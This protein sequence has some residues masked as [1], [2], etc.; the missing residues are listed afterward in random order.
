M[1][2]KLEEVYETGGWLPGSY[3]RD[4]Y[5]SKCGSK[6]CLIGMS[7]FLELKERGRETT[8]G[9]NHLN[10]SSLVQ[11]GRDVCPT[12]CELI[13][14][15]AEDPSVKDFFQNASE[16]EKAE[17][18]PEEEWQYRPPEYFNDHLT[19]QIL[20]EHGLTF[21][22]I[23]E[24]DELARQEVLA[25]IRRTRARLLE[26]KAETPE[27]QEPTEEEYDGEDQGEKELVEALV[28]A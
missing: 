5:D 16:E 8:T 11:E 9:S 3:L 14:A 1:L 23:E 15:F 4:S 25:M 24:A 27:P 26:F 22:E 17:I 20:R 21:L 2:D 19:S 6:G 7:S 12:T 10:R 18:Y 28:T 13:L